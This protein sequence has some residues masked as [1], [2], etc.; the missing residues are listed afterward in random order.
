MIKI[1]DRFEFEKSRYDWRLHEW[2]E[3]T[4]KDGEPTRNKKTT[5]HP[6]LRRLY[7]AV[8][9]RCVDTTGSLE[10]ILAKLDATKE[11]IFRALEKM[12]KRD[13]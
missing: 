6:S 9:E 2:N 1:N 13:E 7:N 12:E 11:E 3:G 8:V 10:E 4:N 5:F